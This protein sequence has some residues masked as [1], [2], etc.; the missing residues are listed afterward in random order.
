MRDNDPSSMA[1]EATPSSTPGAG[2]KEGG[3]EENSIAGK[4]DVACPRHSI[5]SQAGWGC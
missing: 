5:A 4:V 3:R 1:D 2:H